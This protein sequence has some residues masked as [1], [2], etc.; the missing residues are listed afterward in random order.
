MKENLVEVLELEDE[1]RGKGRLGFQTWVRI[2]G[3]LHRVLRL[4][5]RPE[6]VENFLPS[7]VRPTRTIELQSVTPSYPKAPRGVT[8]GA[9]SGPKH[10]HQGPSQNLTSP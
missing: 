10:R 8:S 9:W 4:S 6:P 5:K 3:M 1:R 2:F 7:L